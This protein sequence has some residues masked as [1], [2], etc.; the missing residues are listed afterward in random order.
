MTHAPA[1]KLTAKTLTR[2]AVTLLACSLVH[3]PRGASAQTPQV[4]PPAAAQPAETVRLSVIFTDKSGRTATD[5]RPEDVRVSENGEQQT[6]T[7]VAPEELPVTFALLVDNSRSLANAFDTIIR[8]AASVASVVR[9]GDEATVIRFVGS[10]SIKTVEDFTGDRESLV[11][12]PESMFVEGGPTAVVDA[13]RHAV[14]KVAE[15]GGSGRRRRAVV[16]LTDGEDRESN[17]KL[18][19]LAKLLRQQDVQVFVLAFVYLLSNEGGFI[20]KAP[21][22]KAVALM[23]RI[24]EESGGRAFFPKDGAALKTAVEEIKRN[25]RAQY[26]VEYRPTDAARDGKFR[27]VQVKA[28][29]DRKAFARPGYFAGK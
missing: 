4:A 22:E 28:T 17:W 2:F 19:E 8:T 21:R 13:V 12:A 23:T 10:D 29:G 9:P 14:E 27:R 25:L 24:A 5:V 26:A 20:M 15:R 1:A 16:L 3:A 18:D 6:V 11:T 7:R